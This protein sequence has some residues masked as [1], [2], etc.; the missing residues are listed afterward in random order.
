[1]SEAVRR[2]IDHAMK[3]D[4]SERAVVAAELIASLDGPAD[5]DAEQA[6]AVEIDRRLAEIESGDAEFTSWTEL[7][8]RIQR[9][10]LHR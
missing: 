2:I 9:E 7:R 8:A 4:D 10:I 3:L 1:M 6:W 5:A